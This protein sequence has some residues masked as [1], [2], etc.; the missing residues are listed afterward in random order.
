MIF[1]SVCCDDTIHQ[2][3]WLWA[4]LK[5]DGYLVYWASNVLSKEHSSNRRKLHLRCWQI[6]GMWTT[7]SDEFTHIV[8]PHD[9][10]SNVPKQP[11]G[12][13]PTTFKY[14]NSLQGMCTPR[15]HITAWP[16]DLLQSCLWHD[17]MIWWHEPLT[18]QNKHTFETRV[19]ATNVE[20]INL[21][22]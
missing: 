11:L 10:L 12:Y 18:V 19:Y 20:S 4:K 5:K 22:K 2:A 3:L 8:A 21:A 7:C 16:E 6:H 15:A 14:D 13:F 17:W 9:R 1:V